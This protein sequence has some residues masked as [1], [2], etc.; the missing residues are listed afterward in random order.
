MSE[1]QFEKALRDGTVRDS[2]GEKV[3]RTDPAIR[4]KLMEQVKAKATRLI[5]LRIPSLT[6]NAPMPSP[7]SKV[8]AIRP[9]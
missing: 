4:Q 9:Y 7:S 3:Q 8:S 5:A 6:S 1:R 2:P